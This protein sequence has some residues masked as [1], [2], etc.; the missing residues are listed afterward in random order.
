LFLEFNV[1]KNPDVLLEAMQD[2]EK[3]IACLYQ[4]YSERFEEY[5]DFWSDLA[6]EERKHAACFSN[7]RS[8]LQENPDIVI[9]ER[10]S[11]DAIKSSI[12]YVNELIER[13]ADPEFELINAFSL[14]VKL[15]E[16]LLEKKFF[17]VLDGE[18]QEIKDTL[19]LLSTETER[20]F[21][22]LKSTL[23]DYKENIL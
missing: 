13:A 20:H 2:H 12:K 18:T 9:V 8:Q 17:D 1:A 15:E 22:T 11:T 16:A 23:S 10:F 3:A 14:A 19:L 21:Q 5:A 4:A 7:L 6:K